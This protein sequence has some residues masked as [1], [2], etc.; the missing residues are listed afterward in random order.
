[1]SRDDSMLYSGLSSTRKV[2]LKKAKEETT[3]L[4]PKAEDV[5]KVLAEMKAEVTSVDR[6]VLDETITEDAKLRR[7]ERI[8]GDYELLTKLEKRMK[9]LLGVAEQTAPAEDQEAPKLPEYTLNLDTAPKQI[10]RWIDRGVKLSCETTSHP[11]HQVWK[12]QPMQQ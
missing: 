11:F 5:L 1:M 9:Q 12:R 4:E 8:R 7:I 3:K 2:E 10:H 6:I